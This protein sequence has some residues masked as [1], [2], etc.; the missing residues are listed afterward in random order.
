LVSEVVAK[1]CRRVP[2]QFGFPLGA[3]QVLCPQKKGAVGTIALNK[4][5]RPI[6]NPDEIAIPGMPLAIGDRVIQTVNNY[7]LEIFNGDIGR[8]IG[9]NERPGRLVVEF[10]DIQGPRLVEIPPANLED[11]QLAYALTVH[12][13]QGSEFPCVV[14]PIHTTNHTMLKRNL[15]YTAVT[16]AR[17]MIVLV[18]TM[19]A[20]NTAIRT[21]DSSTRWSNLEK[22]I[23]DG[24][25]RRE[26]SAEA[27][28][29]K[30]GNRQPGTCDG[31]ADHHSIKA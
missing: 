11:L 15:L 14:M 29:D 24:V 5:L 2:E 10:E 4:V 18:G 1:V 30:E 8:V 22:F 21:L 16:R 17:K 3:I 12:K 6:L 9:L 20:V 31:R 28:G 26:N 27:Y 7:D 19:K 23:T 25:P 13:S